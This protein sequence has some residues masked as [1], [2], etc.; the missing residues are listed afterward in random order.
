MVVQKDGHVGLRSKEMRSMFSF[1]EALARHLPSE[2]SPLNQVAKAASGTGSTGTRLFQ[3][4]TCA[5]KR[6]AAAASAFHDL[7]LVTSG[8]TRASCCHAPETE[9]MT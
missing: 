1:E 7:I 9:K 3:S 8:R 4:L 5:Q 6:A 2:V